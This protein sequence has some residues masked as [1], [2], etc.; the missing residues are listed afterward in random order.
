MLWGSVLALCRSVIDFKQ[1]SVATIRSFSDA[2]SVAVFWQY[3]VLFFIDACMFCS[4][5]TNI[6]YCV[7]ATMVVL[8]RFAHSVAVFGRYFDCSLMSGMLCSSAINIHYCV[9]TAMRD[10]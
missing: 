2:R 6:H 3:F 4:S 9:V 5:A 8:Y 7:V 1:L 10:L